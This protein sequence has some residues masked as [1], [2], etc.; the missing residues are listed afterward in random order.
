MKVFDSAELV[1]LPDP[2]PSVSRDPKD[3]IFLA[4]AVVG[5]ARYLVSEDLDLLV[6]KEYK[7]VR[8]VNIPTFFQIIQ[9]LA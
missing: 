9:S 1:V 2:V 4:C 6:L 8:I 7:G 3:D 5:H